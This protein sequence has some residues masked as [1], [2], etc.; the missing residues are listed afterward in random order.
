MR[1]ETEDVRQE[2]EDLRQKTED[3]RQETSDGDVRQRHE[4]KD[5]RQ[6]M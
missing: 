4:K 3:V 6:D 5:L 2:T 1:Q